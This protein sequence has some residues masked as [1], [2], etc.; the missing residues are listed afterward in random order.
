MICPHADQWHGAEPWRTW[1]FLGHFGGQTSFM[2]DNCVDR[3]TRGF[4]TGGSRFLHPVC[5]F[6]C[7][8]RHFTPPSCL[9]LNHRAPTEVSS[10]LSSPNVEVRLRTGILRRR[11][12]CSTSNS[13]GR[14][15]VRHRLELRPCEAVASSTSRRMAH[16][17]PGQRGVTAHSRGRSDTSPSM[18]SPAG[19]PATL[20]ASVRWSCSSAT[21]AKR[22]HEFLRPPPMQISSVGINARLIL[23]P[24]YRISPNRGN[25]GVTVGR[26]GA[27][28]ACS[29]VGARSCLNVPLEASAVTSKATRAQCSRLANRCLLVHRNRGWYLA[30]SSTASTSSP[31]M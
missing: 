17:I 2:V 27:A 18:E 19:W 7:D 23:L 24:D 5:G 30:P 4:E 28:H 21:T 22:R 31:A 1:R 6:R 11:R 12:T 29:L 8:S 10:L 15:M 13:P 20:Q 16:A 3:C 14:P 26:A 25:T 9:H